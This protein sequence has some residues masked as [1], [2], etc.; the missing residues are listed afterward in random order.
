[1]DNS[2]HC[3]PCDRDVEPKKHIGVGTLLL[4]LITWG[5]WLLVIP[6]Y[7]KRC[8]LCRGTSL[9][10]YQQAQSRSSVQDNLNDTPFRII[11]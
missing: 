8:T 2:V 6:L 3:I 5:L 7:K 10:P 4:V 11:S 1:M 9:V